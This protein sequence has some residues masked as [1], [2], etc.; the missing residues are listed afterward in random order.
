MAELTS[1][2]SGGIFFEAP[3]WH[4]DSWWVSDFYDHRVSRVSAEGKAEAV[5]EVENQPSGLGWLPDGSLV[6]TSMLDHRVLRFADGRLSTLADVSELAKQI[7]RIGIRRFLFGSDFNVLTPAEEITN[8]GN[9][10]LTPEEW[11]ILSQNCAPW[12]C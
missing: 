4:E 10:G 3:R 12:A 6:V 5:V 7:R 2:V 9:L 8:L 1:L 11:R